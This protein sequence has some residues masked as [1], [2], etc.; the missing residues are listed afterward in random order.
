[1][2]TT[3]KKDLDKT[4]F[5]AVK[6]L[7]HERVM[8]LFDGGP[9]ITMEDLLQVYPV[10][11]EVGPS[12]RCNNHCE[13][14]MHGTYY[15]NGVDMPLPLYQKLIDEVSSYG[16]DERTK[17]VIFSSSGEPLM[18]PEIVE[19]MRHTKQRGVDVALITNGS[20]FGRKG[21]IEAIAEDVSWVRVSL[22]AGTPETRAKIHGVGPADYRNVLGSLSRLSD[23]KRE[24]GSSLNIGAQ[25]VVTEENREEIALACRDVKNA[26]ADYFQIKPVV[27]HPQDGREQLSAEFWGRVL[28]ESEQAKE[29]HQDS[30]FDVFVKYDQFHAIMK[31]DHDRSAYDTCRAVF[32]PIVEA[33]GKVYHCSQTRGLDSMEL[34]D[35]NGQSFREIWESEKRKKIVEGI[36]LAKCQPVCR[37]HA[38]NAH[39]R[40]F[41]ERGY[42]PDLKRRVE[43]L[44]SVGGRSPNFV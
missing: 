39:L 27:F 35:L 31:P 43:D 1:M 30:G 5:S 33:D 36:D 17:G 10:T 42:T 34:G 32:F 15:N 25:I 44:K 29:I 41:A 3:R 11:L 7:L 28:E 40:Y 2:E 22:N 12:G 37:C 26:G 14:C 21:L 4:V 24:T 20:G 19:F 9:G 23:K 16:E 38:N 8:G 13:F 18:Q 6:M